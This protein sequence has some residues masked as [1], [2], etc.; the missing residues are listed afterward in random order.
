MVKLIDDYEASREGEGCLIRQWDAQLLERASADMRRVAL[1]GQGDLNDLFGNDF[2]D[3]IVSVCQP[4]QLQG[5]I[6]GRR[7]PRYI[8][9]REYRFPQQPM[10]RHATPN[11]P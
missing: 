6:I 4:K 11:R 1:S 8:L 2:R 10:Q 3:W 5:S 7:H 9:R